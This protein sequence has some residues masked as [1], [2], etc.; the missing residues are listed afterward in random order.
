MG[1]LTEQ[2]RDYTPKLLRDD[3]MAQL[4]LLREEVEKP[5]NVK[6]YVPGP[7]QS[8]CSFYLLTFLAFLPLTS[9]FLP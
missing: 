1:A 5:E 9:H 4:R 7:L 6:K 2:E 8:T 3:L